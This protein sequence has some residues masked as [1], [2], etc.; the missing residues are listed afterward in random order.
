VTI[1]FLQKIV[2]KSKFGHKIRK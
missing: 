1:L 2:A